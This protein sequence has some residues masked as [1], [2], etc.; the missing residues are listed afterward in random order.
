MFRVSQDQNLITKNAQITAP[1]QTGS[2]QRFVSRPV[3]I[4]LGDECLN[5]SHSKFGGLKLCYAH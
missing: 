1:W 4:Q 5:V 2:A 3:K